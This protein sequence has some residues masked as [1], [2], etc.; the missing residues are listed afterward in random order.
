MPRQRGYNKNIEMLDTG[1]HPHEE[2]SLRQKNG[3]IREL[4]RELRSAPR[5][6]V[7]GEKKN[8]NA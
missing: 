8:K 3:K 6:H 7:T 5:G 4:D 2:P 1:R